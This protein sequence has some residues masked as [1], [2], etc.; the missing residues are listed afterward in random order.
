L[1]YQSSA[2][3]VRKTDVLL[4]FKNSTATPFSPQTKFVNEILEIVV[5]QKYIDNDSNNA[6]DRFH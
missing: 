2:L 3:A 1:E 5:L 4:I 6:K